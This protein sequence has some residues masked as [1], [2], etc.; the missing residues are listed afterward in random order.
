MSSALGFVVSRATYSVPGTSVT[1]GKLPAAIMF[2]TL[3]ERKVVLPAIT[4]AHFLRIRHAYP[5]PRHRHECAIRAHLEPARQHHETQ[6]ERGAMEPMQQAHHTQHEPRP[7]GIAH[8]NT[9]L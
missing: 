7:A 2:S 6:Y 8:A 9:H 5:A 4:P 1:V 3:S